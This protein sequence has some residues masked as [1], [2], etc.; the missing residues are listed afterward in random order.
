MNEKI[1]FKILLDLVMAV[2]YVLIMFATGLG[3]FFHEVAGI[4]V[5]VLFAV[6]II[7]NRK[8]LKA[9]SRAVKSDKCKD[10]VKFMYMSDIVLIVFMPVAIITGILIS[11]VLFDTGIRGGT[12]AIFVIH[13]AASYVCLAVLALHTALHAKYISAVAKNIFRNR[14]LPAVKKAAGRFAAGAMAAFVLYTVAYSGYKSLVGGSSGNGSA[15]S[16]SSS[17]ETYSEDGETLTED[18]SSVQT[19]VG[20]SGQTAEPSETLEEYL[21]KLFC[22]GCHNH[23]PLSAPLC[24]KSAEQIEQATEDYNALYNVG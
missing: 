21:S 12:Y 6:H 14:R 5:G 7:V 17:D 20:S 4:A 10:R 11:R 16:A 18:E 13:E 9:M 19:A 23:C 15:T 24:T 3:S 2:L 1:V 8:S 22:T